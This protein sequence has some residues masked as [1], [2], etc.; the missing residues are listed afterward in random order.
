L[1]CARRPQVGLEDRKFPET[2]RGSPS[3]AEQ[4]R[5]AIP[6]TYV[7]WQD[8]L[9]AQQCQTARV[10]N[11]RLVS[12]CHPPFGTRR[13]RLISCATTGE[14]DLLAVGTPHREPGV[15]EILDEAH[16]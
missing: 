1:R 3:A 5:V 14:E 8:L 15:N 13:Q 4:Y 16:G 12:A 9:L 11:R 10:L 6:T 2:C 7:H